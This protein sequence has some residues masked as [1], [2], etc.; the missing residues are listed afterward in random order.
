MAALGAVAKT[1]V[2][3]E[4]NPHV[5]FTD[6][7]ENR[8]WAVWYAIRNGKV[9]VSGAAKQSSGPSQFGL[10]AESGWVVEINMTTKMKD[11][12]TE[13][14]QLDKQGQNA[15]GSEIRQFLRVSGN[16]ACLVVP[17]LTRSAESKQGQPVWWVRD[18]WNDAKAVGVFRQTELTSREK[19]LTAHE[20][21]E[22]RSPAPVEV[23]M[24]ENAEETVAAFEKL[25]AVRQDQIV[26]VVAAAGYPLYQTEIAEQTGMS[27]WMIG[28]CVRDMIKAGDVRLHRRLE[29]SEERADSAAGRFHYLYWHESPVPSRDPSTYRVTSG[30]MDKVN[31]L[32]EGQYMTTRWL[33]SGVRAEIQELI[34]AGLL[35]LENEGTDDERIVVPANVPAIEESEPEPSITVK[36][37]AVPARVGD[38]VA[39]QIAWLVEAEIERRVAS[40]LAEQAVQLD[41]LG[42]RLAEAEIE[43]DAAR[44]ELREAA[45]KLAQF[46]ALLG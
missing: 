6:P 24:A 29:T 46:R 39:T 43:R 40:R 45:E 16:A 34:D 10:S 36:A 1:T 44:A 9:R 18:E 37:P 5:G 30:I 38:T 26:E 31:A 25:W 3:G 42:A 28:R 33:S 13:F 32:R 15:F 41:G 20:A 17:G 12:W 19:R 4:R 35:V 8:A 22:D 14:S 27:N 21:G 11:L 23:R 7:L 2:R